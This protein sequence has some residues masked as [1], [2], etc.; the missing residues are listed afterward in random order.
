MKQLR[1]VIARIIRKLPD[2]EMEAV[3]SFL[4][5][6]YPKEAFPEI[7]PALTST[8][9]REEENAQKLMERDDQPGKGI[10]LGN[11]HAGNG[12]AHPPA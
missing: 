7:V 5:A 3:L 8:M 4:G 6:Q 11:P 10:S 2:K 12:E 9:R 1:P